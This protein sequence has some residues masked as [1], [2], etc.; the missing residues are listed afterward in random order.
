VRPPLLA[1]PLLLAVVLGAGAL[2]APSRVGRAQDREPPPPTFAEVQAL[3][4]EHCTRCHAGERAPR[5]QDLSPEQAWESIVDRPSEELPALMRVRPGRPD[6]SY[7]YL[8]ITDRHLDAGGRG[9]RMPLG[10]APLPPAAIRT[11]E[12]WIL[13]GAPR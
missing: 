12:R 5:G 8:K 1:A 9:R 2:T 3:F 7:L 4:V 6:E 10:Q 13:A 11:I